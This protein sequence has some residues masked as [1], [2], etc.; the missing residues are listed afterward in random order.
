MEVG[1]LLHFSSEAL[2][3]RSGINRLDLGNHIGLSGALGAVLSF[4]VYTLYC[5]VYMTSL[6]RS[7]SC[8]YRA[9][10]TIVSLAHLTHDLSMKLI[11]LWDDCNAFDLDVGSAWELLRCNASADVKI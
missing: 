8:Y 5:F 2:L 6:L 10:V 4:L 9:I 11:F 7:A 1:A 3:G